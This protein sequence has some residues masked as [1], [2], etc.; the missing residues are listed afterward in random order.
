MRVAT[1]A[2]V[3]SR[4]RVRSP[5]W[6][7]SRT[8]RSSTWP[9]RGFR[10]S[11][12]GPTT[13]GT[14]HGSPR[15]PSWRGMTAC[16][17]IRS[18][19]GLATSGASATCRNCRPD[20]SRLPEHLRRWVYVN[21]HFRVVDPERRTAWKTAYMPWTGPGSRPQCMEDGANT[22]DD[23]TT[24]SRPGRAASARRNGYSIIAPSCT[25]ATASQCSS[26]VVRATH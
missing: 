15:R 16:R 14:C 8:P 10:P 2:S 3:T 19:H 24:L 5:G 12:H 25:C 20:G 26:S 18:V 13:A 22:L 1:P 4:W 11:R 23:S 6:V 17:R 21:Q 7:N 9:G